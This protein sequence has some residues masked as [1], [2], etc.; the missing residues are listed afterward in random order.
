MTRE[1]EVYKIIQP[2]LEGYTEGV[3]WDF[4]REFSD[5]ASITKD[6]LAFSNSEYQGDSY[7]IIGIEE[8]SKFKKISLTKSDRL[9]LK[10]DASYI[11]LSN[12][13]IVGLPAKEIEELNKTSTDLYQYIASKMLISIPEFEFVP[14]QIKPKIWLGVLIIKN[15]IGVFIS[16]E[17]LKTKDGAKIEVKQG[18]IYIRKGDRT[19]TQDATADEY[20]RIWKKYIDALECKGEQT[21]E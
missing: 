14:I 15:K 16:K 17:D 5:R 18:V 21:N 9:R 1:Q 13:N 2:L 10:T 12:I 20:I 7:I 6:I 3:Y 4:K 11:Y 8:S 19:L